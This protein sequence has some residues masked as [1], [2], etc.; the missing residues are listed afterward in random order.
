MANKLYEETDIA[1]I[2][3]AIRGKNGSS[4]TYTVSQMANAI[5]NIPSGG[6]SWEFPANACLGSSSFTSLPSD[7]VFATRTSCASLFRLCS[8]MTT[9]PSASK[10]DTSSVTTM[11]EMFGYCSA[12]NAAGLPTDNDGYLAYDTSSCTNF[13]G[14]FR[15]CTNLASVPIL[16]GKLRYATNISN[17]FNGCS[18]LTTINANFGFLSSVTNASNMFAGC[19]NLSSS[20]L[21][22]IMSSGWVGSSLA[23]ANKTLKY[24]GFTSG[25]ATTITGLSAWSTLSSNGWTTGY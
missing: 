8:S 22:T 18:S 24:L 7:F 5:A 1:A 11:Q 19:T 12:L 20:S 2:A 21:N 6:T 17:M 9:A 4:D 15:N 23:S 16:F 3:T 25:Q 14:M 13:N 10:L